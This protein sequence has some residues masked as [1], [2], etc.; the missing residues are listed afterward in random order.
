MNLKA[1]RRG[2]LASLLAAVALGAQAAGQQPAGQQA[3]L[4]FVVT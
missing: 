2:A 4:T 3:K 1:L